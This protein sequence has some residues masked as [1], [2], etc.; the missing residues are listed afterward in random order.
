[1]GFFFCGIFLV[2]Q[3][4]VVAV[5][6]FVGYVG[7]VAPGLNHIGVILTPIYHSHSVFEKL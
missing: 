2:D 6:V 5:G 4:F 1:M 3:E 7:N